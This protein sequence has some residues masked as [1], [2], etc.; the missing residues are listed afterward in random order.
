[1]FVAWNYKPKPLG[2]KKKVP[3]VGSESSLEQRD[4]ETEAEK[5]EEKQFLR[6]YHVFENNELENMFKNILN[7]KV[8]ESFYEQ[9]NW[10]AIFEKV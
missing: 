3:G 10:C 8:V 4:T 7:A 9:G 1:L 6:F 5:K 2:N